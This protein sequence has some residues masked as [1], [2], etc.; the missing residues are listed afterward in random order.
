MGGADQICTDKTGTLTQNIMTV[1][2]IFYE[3]GVKKD[4]KFDG[5][6]NSASG[7]LFAECI[8]FNSTAFM[9]RDGDKIEF[10]GN[11]SEMGLMKYIHYS[12]V[13]VE[14]MLE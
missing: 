4:T 1:Q 6:L 2:S 10:E 11:P 3:G 5:L 7:Q 8:A 9:Q 13:P 12:G 14:S